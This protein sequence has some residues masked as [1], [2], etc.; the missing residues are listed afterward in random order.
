MDACDSVMIGD[1]S[2]DMEMGRA[3]GFRTIGVSW[4]YHDVSALEA[5]GA[6]R[7]IHGYEALDGA[8]QAI[9]EG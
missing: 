8:L 9:W 7:V 2:F 6:D 1:T 4:G 5:A 3:A